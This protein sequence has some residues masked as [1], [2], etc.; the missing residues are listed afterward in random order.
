MRMFSMTVVLKRTTSWNTMEYLDMSVSG[1]TVFMSMPPSVMVPLP[2][3][4]NLVAS[5]ATVDFPLP[6]GPTSAVTS[7][8]FAVNEMSES[9]CCPSLYENPTFLNSMS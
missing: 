2:V 4:Q 6:E 3:S 7:P 5:L 8:C 9:T 1:S